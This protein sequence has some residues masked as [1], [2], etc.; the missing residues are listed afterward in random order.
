MSAQALSLNEE[1]PMG[2]R[3]AARMDEEPERWKA[4]G[5]SAVVHE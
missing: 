3:M 5:K 4:H 2:A 1:T